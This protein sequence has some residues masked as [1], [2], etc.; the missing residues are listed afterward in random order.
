MLPIFIYLPETAQYYAVK[1]EH[2]RGKAALRKVNGGIPD[3]DDE[4]EY[5]IIRN[6]IEEEV[7]NN[8]EV[9]TGS[10]L[11]QIVKS[12]IACFRGVSLASISFST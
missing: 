3:Y 2:D 9:D 8:E 1:G 5:A 4:L 10:N 12:Y 7:S 6:T 11:G